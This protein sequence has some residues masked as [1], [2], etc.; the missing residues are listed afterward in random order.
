MILSGDN[1][2]SGGTTIAGGTLELTG[3]IAVGT[4][5]IDF[6]GGTL[7]IDN[8]AFSSNAFAN[9]IFG[10]EL[11]DTIELTGL[12]FTSG[13]HFAFQSGQV[14]VIS[15]G[16][17]DVLTFGGSHAA[18]D[19]KLGQ[20]GSGSAIIGTNA[21]A[22]SEIA[23]NAL[24]RTFPMVLPGNYT[25]DLTG[26]INLTTGLSAIDLPADASLTINS[27]GHTIDGNGN[28]SGWLSIR[29]R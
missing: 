6:Q 12:G 10:F 3:Q 19:F 16:T 1:T 24:I 15:G 4:G 23:L 18:A 26:N 9:E 27:N 14:S 25:I 29:A 8:A 2:Y 7:A 5:A 17:T 11:G 21:K 22:G 20:A 13:A 28:Q